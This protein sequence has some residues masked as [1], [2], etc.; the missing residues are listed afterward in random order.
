VVELAPY[1]TLNT[2]VTLAQIKSDKQLS[3]I[4][5]VK[6]SR[7][8]VAAITSDEFNRILELGDTEL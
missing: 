2:P 7:L 3:S 8:S 6:Q 1:K 5:L 4:Q